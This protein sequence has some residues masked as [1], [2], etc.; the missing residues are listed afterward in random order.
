MCNSFSSFFHSQSEQRMDENVDA[1]QNL[2][3]TC[4]QQQIDELDMLQSIFCNPGELKIDDHS[5]L[6]DIN[7]YLDGKRMQLNQKLDYTITLSN[8][9]G[10]KIEMHFELP[11]SY[12]LIETPCL[13]IRTTLDQNHKSAIENAMKRGAIEFADDLDKSSVYVYQ[14][15]TWLQENW[16]RIAEEHVESNGKSETVTSANGTKQ[17]IEMER[18]WI[19]SHHL[20]ST[21]KRQDLLKLAKELDL[22]GFSKP[23]KP[24]IICVEGRKEDT[25]E[26][27]KCIRQWAWQRIT[28]RLAE[29][30]MRAEGNMGSFRRFDAFKEK[31]HAIGDAGDDEEGNQ[32]M[33]MGTF[34]KFLEQHQ[35]NYVKKELFHFE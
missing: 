33:D 13:S 18:L 24:G 32:P 7:E 19:Y 14:I 3:K 17:P 15:V 20:K 23:G 26:F 25:Q 22:S 29:S 5:V 2:L 12:P 21:T 11:H 10:R 30:K 35:C 9:N 27:W 16:E 4:L 8:L 6:A 31:L 1:T 28:V 34:M